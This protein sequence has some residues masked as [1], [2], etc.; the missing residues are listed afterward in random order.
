MQDPTENP[1]FPI[2]EFLNERIKRDEEIKEHWAASKLSIAQKL[3]NN[4][5]QRLVAYI[6][7]LDF[8][9]ETFKPE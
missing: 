9:E 6:D 2:I 8:I 7:V 3:H 1:A 4:A 5:V